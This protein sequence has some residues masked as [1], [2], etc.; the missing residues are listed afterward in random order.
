MRATFLGLPEDRSR[1]RVALIPA[2]YDGTTSWRPGTRF[3]PAAILAASP[4]LEFFDEET[5]REPHRTLGFYT[6]PQ[7]EL[8]VDPGKALE[9]L[10]GLVE[11]A[12]A[13]GKFPVLLGGEHTVTLAA[14]RALRKRHFPFRI[15]QIDAHPDL[16]DTYQGS[17]FSHACVMRRALEL[18]LEV[19]AVGVR[20]AS[21]E[22]YEFIRRGRG[23]RVFWAREVRKDFAS[24]LSRLEECLHEVPL[25]VTIDLDGLDPSE[26]PGV[27]TP[28]PGGLRWEELMEIL[29]RVSRARVLGFDLVELLPLPGDPR[30][31]YL[32]ARTVYKFLAYLAENNF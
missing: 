32:A 6:Y 20:T 26:A 5:E 18:G 29:R 23:Y 13:E 12:L 25:Y 2:P 16:R 17:P 1:A 10:E 27:G 3:G 8:P 9:A 24:F 28:E 19:V 11:E 21:R 31:E 22:E 4:Q 7:P 15:L 30:T 14:L